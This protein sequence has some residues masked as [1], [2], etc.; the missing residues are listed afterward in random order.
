MNHRKMLSALLALTMIAGCSSKGGGPSEGQSIPESTPEPATSVY[1]YEN[2]TLHVPADQEFED[3][4]AEGYEYSLLSDRMVIFLTSETKKELADAGA[5]DI[6]LEEYADYATRDSAELSLSKISDICM[7]AK[8]VFDADSGAKYRYV[9]DLIE[10]E[11]RFWIINYC[12][13]DKDWADLEKTMEECLDLVE[14][15]Q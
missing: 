1:T 14:I 11:D 9:T 15:K 2:V 3:Y 5:P 4:D 10:T 13:L 7:R 6:T 12:C 8:Y